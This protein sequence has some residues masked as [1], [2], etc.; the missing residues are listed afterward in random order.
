MP[1]TKSTLQKGEGSPSGRPRATCSIDGCDRGGKLTRGMC[2]RCYRYWLDHTPKDQRKVAPRFAVQFWDRVQKTH[3]HGCWIWTGPRDAKGYGRWG[4]KGAH[5]HAWQEANGQL[6][7]GQWILHHC[8]NPPCVNPAHLYPGTVVENVR[9]MVTRGRGYVPPRKAECE[10]G[11]LIA[12]ANLREVTT[13]GGEVR[14]YCRTCDNQRSAARQRDARR[15]RGLLKTRLS[16]EERGRI[17]ALCEGGMSRRKVAVQVGR[18]LA[19]VNSVMAR[20]KADGDR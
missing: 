15:S 2:T 1:T 13:S 5:R 10:Q 17:R 9:D 16:D 6:P 4:K 8:D 20:V 18:S 19:A 12:G 11:H 3:E 7:E 14:R